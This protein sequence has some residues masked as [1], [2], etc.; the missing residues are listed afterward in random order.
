[1]NQELRRL[2]SGLGAESLAEVMG[3]GGGSA[4][5]LLESRLRAIDREQQERTRVRLD[6]LL[7]PPL[8][9]Y[10]RHLLGQR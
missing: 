8:P 9:E 3:Y 4:R 10:V 5:R 7:N 2:I 1:M 6:A